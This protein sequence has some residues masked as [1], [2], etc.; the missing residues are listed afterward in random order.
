MSRLAPALAH[1]FARH[2]SCGLCPEGHPGRAAQPHR[3]RAARVMA[4]A[5]AHLSH[6]PGGTRSAAHACAV[7]V[8]GPGAMHLWTHQLWTHHSR[9]L[10]LLYSHA[11]CTVAAP[12]IAASVSALVLPR[13]RWCH[14][15]VANRRLELPC[16]TVC[17]RV[18][19]AR[20]GRI[21]VRPITSSRGVA[22]VCGA[23]G[24]GRWL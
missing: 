13:T 7:P 19:E 6:E 23:S 4:R 22:E 17:Y 9:T 1:A 8:A 24:P 16:V 12:R 18:F 11:G 15:C 10:T 3:M 5:A 20:T 14:G 21:Q 2:S